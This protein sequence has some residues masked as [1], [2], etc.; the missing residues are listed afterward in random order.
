M[1][2]LLNTS[3]PE[4]QVIIGD[5][6]NQQQYSWQAGRELAYGMHDFIRDCL[7][8]NSLTFS[9]IKGIG[10]YRGPGSYTGL[11]IGCTVGNTLATA[12]AVPV[13]GGE[14]DMWISACLKLLDDGENHLVVLP[15]YG[16]E[17][18]I[19]APRK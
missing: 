7:A 3:T 15:L 6:R 9:D 2:L 18:H 13:V 14:G 16:G 17:A 8:Q 10:L 11:R 19:T 12:L 1:Y 5:A 4:C